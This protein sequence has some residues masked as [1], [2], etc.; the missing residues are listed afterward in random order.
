MAQIILAI[1]ISITLVQN[2][3]MQNYILGIVTFIIEGI[4]ALF[5]VYLITFHSYLACTNTTTCKNI[6]RFKI[7]V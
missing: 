3:N 5:L 2:D 6:G 7:G 4:F 1:L